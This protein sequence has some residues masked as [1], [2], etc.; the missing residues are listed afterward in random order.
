MIIKTLIP[1]DPVLFKTLL[2]KIHRAKRTIIYKDGSI[3]VEIWDAS[4]FTAN[5]DLMNNISSQLWHRK[6]KAHIVEAIYEIE[7]I[8][9]D[10]CDTLPLN[11]KY[12]IYIHYKNGW[13]SFPV[14]EYLSEYIID[15]D[16]ITASYEIKHIR[17]KSVTKRISHI[18]MRELIYI[19]DVALRKGELADSHTLL[20]TVHGPLCTYDYEYC[21]KSGTDCSALFK[22]EALNNRYY[23]L[24]NKI[25]K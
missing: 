12:D 2:L 18:D 8:N 25:T 10:E 15:N 22:D 7:D 5:S 17:S 3:K 20:R 24:I 4:R 11:G 1:S 16:T 23:D 9:Y 6:D 13:S 14:G 21:G 19:F